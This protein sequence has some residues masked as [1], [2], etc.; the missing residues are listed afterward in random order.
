MEN[1][2][3]NITEE[4][5]SVSIN[6]TEEL[7]EITVNVSEIGVQGPQGPAGTA[8]KIGF[9]DYND[10]TGNVSLSSDTWTD[11]PNNGQGAFTNKTYKPEG[12]NDVIDEETGY[13]DFDKLTLGSQIFIRNDFTVTPNTNNSLLELRYVLGGGD[14]EY[15]LK[16]WSERLDSGSGIGYQRVISFPIY[17][18]DNNTK[19]NPG[20]LQVKLSSDGTVLNA[21]SYIKINLK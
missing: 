1:V 20:K 10:S 21:G 15:A 16:F 19:N 12:V 14:G 5:Q 17:M 6:V 8:T 11:I 13:L 3:I 2:S 7:E 9:I 4:T 18:G